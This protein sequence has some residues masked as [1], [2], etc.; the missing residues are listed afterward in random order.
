MILGI[1]WP[2]SSPVSI[3]LRRT[4][5]SKSCGRSLQRFIMNLSVQIGCSCSVS[6]ILLS[7][8]YRWCLDRRV[9]DNKVFGEVLHRLRFCYRVEF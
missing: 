8:D 2:K 3:I 6:K 5:S 4:S 1:S 7:D 9:V